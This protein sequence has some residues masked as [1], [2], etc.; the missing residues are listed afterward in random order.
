MLYDFPKT[1][2]IEYPAIEY[3]DKSSATKTMITIKGTLARPIF[4]NVSFSG[5][6]VIDKYEFT[7]T[8]ELIDIAFYKNI[9]QGSMV[10]TTIKN[11]KPVLE[12]LGTIRM[13][14]E[15]DKLNISVGEKLGTKTEFSTNLKIS[16]PAKS[17]DEALSI[18]QS[19]TVNAGR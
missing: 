16:A 5:K 8:Y 4:R 10:Y 12:I 18:S 6:I 2:D 1:V 9:K 3:R 14:G 11:G 17:Y 13:S 15:F 7:K 19:F